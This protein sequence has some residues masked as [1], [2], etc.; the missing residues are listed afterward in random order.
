MAAVNR[1]PVVL[2][3]W[4]R[5]DSATAVALPENART[6]LC[7]CLAL[8]CVCFIASAA[9]NSRWQQLKAQLFSGYMYSMLAAGFR[10]KQVVIACYGILKSRASPVINEALRRRAHIVRGI[11]LF[12]C[13]VHALAIDCVRSFAR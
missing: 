4:Q 8:V 1:G 3:V 11:A 5:A 7:V 6:L 2:T 12:T 9:T 10:R 13:Q